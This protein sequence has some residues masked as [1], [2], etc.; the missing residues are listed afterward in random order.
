MLVLYWRNL[1]VDL[2]LH[3][4]SAQLLKYTEHLLQEHL[5][6]GN[7]LKLDT[8][9]LQELLELQVPLEQQEQLDL[10]E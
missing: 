2:V 3:I 4:Y 10:K 8:K 7:Y 5:V 1:L 9:E 6:L